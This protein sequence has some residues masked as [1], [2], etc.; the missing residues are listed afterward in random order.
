MREPF[1]QMLMGGHP[2]SLGRTV[3]VVEMI[4]KEES[5]LEELFQCYKSEDEVVRLRT[6]NAFKRV[7]K[8]HKEW[9]VPYLDRFL[10]EISELDQASAQWTL[11]QL[12]LLMTHDMSE[13]QLFRAKEVLKRNLANHSDWIV[14]AQTMETLSKWSIEDSTLK[15]WLYPHLERLSQDARKSVANKARKVSASL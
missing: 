1:E 3:E 5:L 6:S 7:A 10:H 4:E 8:V 14:L 15:E 9:I 2:N 11:A 12:F 13:A